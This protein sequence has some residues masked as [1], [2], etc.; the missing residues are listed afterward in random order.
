MVYNA[1]FLIILQLLIIC[2]SGSGQVTTTLNI[3]NEKCKDD[4]KSRAYFFIK[5]RIS[6]EIFDSQRLLF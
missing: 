6:G 4:N 1:I 5:S 3:F 2:A